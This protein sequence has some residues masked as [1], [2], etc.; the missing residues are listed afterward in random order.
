MVAG[1]AGAPRARRHPQPCI[2]ICAAARQSMRLPGVGANWRT[3]VGFYAGTAH[4]YAYEPELSKTPW[5]TST[6]SW[7]D[8]LIGLYVPG[9]YASLSSLHRHSP[10]AASSN[11]SDPFTT[12]PYAGK[13]PM[14][15]STFRSVD[16]L[17]ASPH[18]HEWAPS[19]KIVLLSRMSF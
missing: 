4:L 3:C 11:F 19:Q 5:Q 2:K 13:A 1:R 16:T 18:R 14:L 7:F 9:S 8:Q 6:K 12:Y 17:N 10:K 15:K